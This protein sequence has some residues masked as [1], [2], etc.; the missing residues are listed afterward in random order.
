MENIKILN[1]NQFD[2]D[3]KKGQTYQ[4]ITQNNI[5]S[6]NN[7]FNNKQNN[8]TKILIED[9]YDNEDDNINLNI[10]INKYLSKKNINNPSFN[11]KTL[12]K[13]SNTEKNKGYL[14]PNNIKTN[15]INNKKRN[16]NNLNNTKESNEI[17]KSKLL[18][19]IRQQK[20]LKNF[21]IKP[22]NKISQNQDILFK[23]Q[24]KENNKNEKNE[25][26]ESKNIPKILTFLRT[27]KNLALPLK[28]NKVSKDNENKNLNKNDNH[29]KDNENNLVNPNDNLFNINSKLK[30]KINKL[31]LNKRN[32]ENNNKFNTSQ[33][34]GNEAEDFIDYNRFTF[35]NNFDKDEN[36]PIKA[37]NKIKKESKYNYRSI[38]YNNNNDKFDNENDFERNI[39]IDEYKE[40]NN[41]IYINRKNNGEYKNNLNNNN[42]DNNDIQKN[43]NKQLEQ[44]SPN[45]N[46]TKNIKKIFRRKTDNN[47]IKPY[48][49]KK[50]LKNKYN[51]PKPQPKNK[52]K[53]NSRYSY[54]NIPNDN[55]DIQ[56][57]DN[58]HNENEDSIQSLKIEKRYRKPII[59]N[60]F[61]KNSYRDSNKSNSS[62]YYNDIS[63][64]QINL[65]NNNY[66]TINRPI[67]NNKINEFII[68]MNDNISPFNNEQNYY[69]NNNLF[70]NRSPLKIKT[71]NTNSKDYYE[72]RSPISSKQNGASFYYSEKYNTS[73]LIDENNNN[74]KYTNF[75]KFMEPFQRNENRNWYNENSYLSFDI[76]N[77]NKI[78]NN[79][80]LLYR[81]PLKAMNNKNMNKNNSMYIKRVVHYDNNN[82]YFNDS[83]YINESDINNYKNRLDYTDYERKENNIFDFDAPQAIKDSIDDISNNTSDF[84]Y[85][86]SR[87]NQN[88]INTNINT[89]KLNV[90]QSYISQ[91]SGNSSKVYVKKNNQCLSNRS[92]QKPVYIKKLNTVYNFYKGTKKLLSKI[93][94]KVFGAPKNNDNKS[95]ENNQTENNSNNNNFIKKNDLLIYPGITTPRMISENE[96]NNS[97]FT[98]NSMITPTPIEKNQKIIKNEKP[99]NEKIL[100]NK[101]CFQTKL[102]NFYISKINGKNKGFYYMSKILSYK[103]FKLPKKSLYYMSKIKV[104]IY[105]IPLINEKCYFQKVR[106]INTNENNN[107]GHQIICS[108]FSLGG[109]NNTIENNK[110]LSEDFKD[111][112]NKNIINLKQ[113]ILNSN[114]KISS[115]L[116]N[117]LNNNQ[118]SDNFDKSFSFKYNNTNLI[119]SNILSN[120]ED[121]KEIMEI[122]NFNFSLPPKSKKTKFENIKIIPEKNNNLLIINK[123]ETKKYDYNYILD[124]KKNKLS[125]NNNYLTQ[126]VIKHFEEL[127]KESDSL[128]FP[129]IQNVKDEEIKKEETM[130]YL[131]PNKKEDIS[132]I[133]NN[134]FLTENKDE[135][136]KSELINSEISSKNN[137]PRIDFSKEIE[138]AEKYIKELKNKMEKNSK[139]NDFI[140]LLNMLTVDNFNVVFNK[141][142]DLIIKNDSENLTKKDIIGNEYILI[143]VIVD[144]S[145]TEK[146]FVNLYAKLCYQLLIKLKENIYN[147]INFKSILM[148]E[149]KRQFN[150]LNTINNTDNV[151]LEDEKLFIIKKKFLGNIDFIYELINEHVL[152]QDIGFFYLD[153]LFNIF[154]NISNLNEVEKL[155]KYL[156]LEAIVN[157]LS[158]L[159]K[160][161]YEKKSNS[162]YLNNIIENNLNSI[163]LNESLP[164]YLKYKIINLIEKQKN[165]W[166]DSLYEK[167]ILVKGKQN[168]K[169]NKNSISVNKSQKLRKRMHSN[170]N[171]T[172]KSMSPNNQFYNKNELEDNRANTY[173]NSINEENITYIPSINIK[174]TYNNEDIIKLIEKDLQNYE[175]FLKQYSITNKYE[176]EQNIQIGNEF[177]WSIIEDILSKKNIDLAEVIRCYVEVCIYQANDKSK[178]FISNDYIK[179][180]ICYYSTNLTNKERDIIHNKMIALFRN[181]HDI[182]I[183]NF[184]MKEIMGY[185]LYIL[186]ENKLNFIK[187]LNN[188]IGMEEHI[189]IMIAEVIKYAIIS[190]ESKCK[191]YHNDFK[192]T[193]L[194][195]DN[196]IFNKYVTNEI[197]DSLNH[198]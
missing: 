94:E 157:F 63:A 196:S 29:K 162:N 9:N 39:N 137:W 10:N 147:E 36:S 127:N 158:K 86:S 68:H 1:T 70:S 186:I 141:I 140:F 104:K 65:S 69:S 49:R 89:N 37:I 78:S 145:I 48:L 13:K 123:K 50:Y 161:I 2:K 169:K 130:K 107:F 156:C 14:L 119:N 109:K 153:E 117:D 151:N 22:N 166:K 15:N 33:L 28:S 143:K 58:Y 99:I 135:R 76:T 62:Y 181:I 54:R 171:N 84:I 125:E 16:M 179:N 108:F 168:N 75:S 185:L 34:D 27:F 116:S 59:N 38:N 187:D 111:D 189:I 11:N 40:R 52:E 175:I 81:K 102:Y 97:N 197:Q 42:Q 90:S 198:F 46:K 83:D 160:K 150:E 138:Q 21:D 170:K 118:N 51:S 93:N 88:S 60:Y 155:K 18:A 105:K 122:N 126:N 183:D 112:S 47:N 80:K 115:L 61:H 172:L 96:D 95:N 133:I 7:N 74:K 5:L 163:L 132:E 114:K 103:C 165:K 149:C 191:K 24:K 56:T 85:D 110:H 182:C 178:I 82:S 31:N 12:I 120:K 195:V 64:D 136:N 91:K 17:K 164:G 180:I 32:L 57:F 192:Q 190:S 194:F 77:I 43:K 144:K 8:S 113:N 25:K 188:F 98:P 152:S 67:K 159:G 131:T 19:R 44:F 92:N 79:K 71:Y 6:N 100:N 176:L 139:K 134:K 142:Y 73:Q 26:G 173:K 23:R 121:S 20:N 30:P 184:N 146:R 129:L 174:N 55:I 148:E 87:E 124:F 193:K 106:K 101:K 167:S 128:S 154:N 72:K 45:F 4:T 53:Y 66:Y 3:F 41:N 35:R 177:D